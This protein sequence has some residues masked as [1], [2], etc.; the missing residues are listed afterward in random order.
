MSRT[1]GEFELLGIITYIISYFGTMR[2]SL[3]LIGM[4]G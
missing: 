4:I 2:V 1:S 3:A